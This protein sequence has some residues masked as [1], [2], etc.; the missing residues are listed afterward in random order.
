MK[1]LNW[2][3]SALASSASLP[4]PLCGFIFRERSRSHPPQRFIPALFTL[5][6]LHKLGRT[7]LRRYSIFGHIIQTRV[8][9]SFNQRKRAV[10]LFIPP[11]LGWRGFPIKRSRIFPREENVKERKEKRKKEKGKKKK[12]EAITARGMSTRLA[13]H[14]PHH[15]GQLQTTIPRPL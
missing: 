15:N 3:R 9:V 5:L 11:F 12:K 6:G 7:F 8:R 1:K 2:C 10:Y 13:L 14:N 4:S